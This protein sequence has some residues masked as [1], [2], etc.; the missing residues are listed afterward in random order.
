MGT[1]FNAKIS[2]SH[3]GAAQWIRIQVEAYNIGNAQ[4]PQNSKHPIKQKQN[5]AFY[6]LQTQFFIGANYLG[7]SEILT[8]NSVKLLHIN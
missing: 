8:H 7:F 3:A 4:N 1:T 2:T 5:N 6:H